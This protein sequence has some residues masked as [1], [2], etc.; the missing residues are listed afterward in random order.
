MCFKA[1]NMQFVGFRSIG[2]ILHE[3]LHTLG[4]PHTHQRSD[5]DKYINVHFLNIEVDT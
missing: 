5:R 1:E 4:F 3:L 2:L